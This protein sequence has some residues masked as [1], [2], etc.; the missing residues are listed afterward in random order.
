MKAFGIEER[1]IAGDAAIAAWV[2]EPWSK[3]DALAPL[4]LRTLGETLPQA[5]PNQ[6]VPVEQGVSPATEAW[7]ARRVEA[8][9]A[10]RLDERSRVV[11]EEIEVPLEWERLRECLARLE[12]GVE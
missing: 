6:L 5:D 7:Y 10:A 12:S 3:G 2:L 9:A 4:V 1:G 11:Y 8:A